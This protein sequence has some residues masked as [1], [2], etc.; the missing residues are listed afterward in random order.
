MHPPSTQKKPPVVLPNFDDFDEPLK[1]IIVEPVAVRSGIASQL[2]SSTSTSSSFLKGGKKSLGAKKA[3]K[4]INFEEAERRAKEEEE[5][6]VTQEEELKTQR[7]EED[8]NRIFNPTSS[9]YSSRLAYVE[10]GSSSNNNG[11]KQRQSQEIDNME[12]LGMGFGKL[13]FGQQQTPAAAATN[14]N[15]GG[16]GQTSYSSKSSMSTGGAATSSGGGGFGGGFGGSGF[17]S[18]GSGNSFN[19]GANNSTKDAQNRFGG[20][21][22]ISSDMYFE[23]GNHDA[24][25]GS[26]ARE[27][28]QAFQGKSGFGSSDYYGESTQSSSTN[29]NSTTSSSYGNYGEFS[30]GVLGKVTETANDFANKFVSQASDDISSLSKLVTTSG[31]K[32]GEM[33]QDLQSRYS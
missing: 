4:S 3:T 14:S 23:R 27:K 30:E 22:G 29:K 18:S 26:E 5:R 28:L 25:A 16:F 9:G 17:G 31:G 15:S 8:A 2:P 24:A 19:S 6:R 20:A 7:K 10:P 1:P 11:G 33:L 12:R 13:G 32:L 21:K